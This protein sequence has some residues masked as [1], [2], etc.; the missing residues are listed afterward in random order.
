MLRTGKQLQHYVQF[1][2][3]PEEF[4]S[5]KNKF[6]CLC[7]S[8]QMPLC[9]VPLPAPPSVLFCPNPW[10]GLGGPRS[11][12]AWGHRDSLRSGPWLHSHLKHFPK[13]TQ[14]VQYVSDVTYLPDPNSIVLTSMKHC[15]FTEFRPVRSCSK[16][17]IVSYHWSIMTSPAWTPLWAPS[18]VHLME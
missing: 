6:T 14:R 10:T 16:K 5:V 13:K 18:L 15:S 3:Q 7:I 4:R 11:G 1:R 12:H 2:W 17:S 9:I 8:L